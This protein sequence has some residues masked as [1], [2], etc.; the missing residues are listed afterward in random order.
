MTDITKLEK[1]AKP[2]GLTVK[3]CGNGHIQITGGPMLVNWWPSSKKRTAHVG[4][5]RKGFTGVTPERAIKMAME[6]PP[7]A[8]TKDKRQG[9]YRRRKVKMYRT[10]KNC[11]WCQHP[12]SLD[13]EIE[14]TRKAT[15]EH[16]IPLALGGLDNANNQVLACE[17]CNAARGCNMPELEKKA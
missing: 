7:I 12:M 9:S 4:A 11:H 6:A 17:P 5:T 8:H 3:D 13:G 14:G 1:L 10:Q 16:R 2:H 15:L